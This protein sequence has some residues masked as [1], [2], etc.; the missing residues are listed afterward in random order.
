VNLSFSYHH[1]LALRPSRRREHLS[2]RNL[3]LPRYPGSRAHRRSL[4]K[5]PKCQPRPKMLRKVTVGTPMHEGNPHE[6]LLKNVE[7]V[8]TQGG[9]GPDP[10]AREINPI[11]RRG[12]P[13]SE[14]NGEHNGAENPFSDN[15]MQAR[16]GPSRQLARFYAPRTVP[17][18]AGSRYPRTVGDLAGAGERTAPLPPLVKKK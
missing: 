13:K 3:Y 16:R 2:A 5:L 11:A 14:Q 10:D 9:I 18:R 15:P 12:G 6:C 17:W 1:V 7:T 8:S 4:A